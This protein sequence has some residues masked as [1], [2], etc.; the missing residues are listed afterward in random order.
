MDS[1]P[2]DI[3][4]IMRRAGLNK[5]EVDRIWNSRH[6]GHPRGA[7]QNYHNPEE[8]SYATFYHMIAARP[9]SLLRFI[10]TTLVYR[11]EDFRL[12]YTWELETRITMYDNMFRFAETG[13]VTPYRR[14]DFE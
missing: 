6:A 11:T 12:L 2:P 10:N 5:V 13:L 8:A 9:G 1:V 3:F 14:D 7:P 4:E